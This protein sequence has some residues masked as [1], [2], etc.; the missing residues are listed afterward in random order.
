MVDKQSDRL[1]G[2]GDPHAL[3]LPAVA[4][5]VINKTEFKIS[6]KDRAM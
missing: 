1:G 2:I 6:V 5:G 4:Q 3:S